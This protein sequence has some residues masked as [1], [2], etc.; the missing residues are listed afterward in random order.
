MSNFTFDFALGQ[1]VG[2][3]ER[4]NNNDPANSALIF[5]VLAASGLESDS[6]L[7]GYSDLASLL[8]STNNEVT[9][10][11][12]ARKTLTDANIPAASVDITTHRTTLSYTTTQ[13][14]TSIG[15]G[16]SWSKLLICY[17]SDTTS[18]TDA[19]VIP[20]CAFDLRISN[21]AIVPNGNNIL[22]ANPTGYLVAS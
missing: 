4:V 5:V 2:Y 14:F 22:I 9:N 7:R 20:M 8:A 3:H 11:N 17:D 10:V 6:I 19:N 16:D 15:A 21:A 12:Y 18:G 1:T 13:T